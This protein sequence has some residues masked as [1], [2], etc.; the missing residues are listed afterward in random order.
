MLGA[1]LDA[2]VAGRLVEEGLRR[3]VVL[4]HIGKSILRFLPPLVITQE[5][6]DHVA[7]VLLDMLS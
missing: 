5:Q 1:E 6:L 2:P 4:N 3:G 7:G